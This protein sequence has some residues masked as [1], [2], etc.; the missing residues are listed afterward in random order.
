MKNKITF[1]LILFF[2]GLN[3]TYLQAND[4]FNF[5][6]SE[7]EVTNE[8][9]F[10]KGLKRGTAETNNGQTIITA[11]TFEYDKNSN[12]LNANGN[13]EIVDKIKD[14]RIKSSNITYFK[15]IEEIF[16]KGKTEA[17]IHSR[18]EVFSSDININRVLNSL[19]SK[20]KQ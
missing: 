12:I 2:F 5:N 20:K 19:K 13:V 10:F 16:S 18:Y 8:G 1:F 7:I 11:D 4:K 15:N 14:F 6:V 17:L 3:F 9:N